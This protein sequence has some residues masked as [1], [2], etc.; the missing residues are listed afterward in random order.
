MTPRRMEKTPKTLIQKFS[1]PHKPPINVRIV[2]EVVL[3]VAFGL[4]NPTLPFQIPSS[5]CDFGWVNSG[6]PSLRGSEGMQ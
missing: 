1:L 4:A 6:G 2:Q 3:V 5:C